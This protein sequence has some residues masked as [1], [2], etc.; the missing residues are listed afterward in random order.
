MWNTLEAKGENPV[1][2]TLEELATCLP[3]DAGDRA[4]A[5]CFYVLQREGWI[6]RIAPTDRPG[7]VRLTGKYT[8]A[9]GIRKKLYDYLKLSRKNVIGVWPDRIAE[10]LDVSREQVTAALRGLEERGAL[11][12]TAPERAGG[13]EILRPGEEL[14]LDESALRRRRER[15]LMKLQR[16]V[17]YAY[18]GCRRRYILEYFGDTPPY[19]RCGDC[20]ACRAGK[21]LNRSSTELTSEQRL[22][23][24]KILAGVARLKDPYAPS[25]V[26]RMLTGSQD[27]KLKKMGF[28]KLSTYGILSHC[29]QSDLEDV[30]DELVRAGALSRHSMTRTIEGRERSYMTVAL[31]EEGWA[32]MRDAERPFSMVWPQSSRSAPTTKLRKGGTKSPGVSGTANKNLMLVLTRLRRELAAREDVP[33]YVVATNRTLEE[34]AN[35][36][37]MTRQAMLEIYGM[38]DKRYERFGKDFLEE[39][40]RVCK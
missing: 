4:V 2:S 31:T 23:I 26:A 29:T 1:F 9:S 24:R 38:G 27:D 18:A 15:E 8:E 17:D 40:R 37:P 11:S 22:T 21:P 36:K 14:E 35:D 5:S 33:D 19:D 39:I 28:D 7:M 25:M 3:S 32:L 16:M 6:R 20:D 12:Y 10:E 13:V 34:M 30:I